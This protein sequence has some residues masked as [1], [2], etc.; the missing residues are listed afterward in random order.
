[1]QSAEIRRIRKIKTIPL[2]FEFHNYYPTSSTTEPAK[3]TEGKMV[4]ICSTRY[5]LSANN[6]YMK[7]INGKVNLR[8]RNVDREM[9]KDPW[10]EKI[11]LKCV[12]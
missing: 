2:N 4:A 6:F 3:I 12:D 7:N 11:K 9:L 10:G 8:E 5:Y 1:M